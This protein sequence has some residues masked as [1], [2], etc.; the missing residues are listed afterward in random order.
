VYRI[1]LTKRY[2]T[3]MSLERVLKVSKFQD[4]LSGTASKVHAISERKPLELMR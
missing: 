1:R 2:C 4:S 3:H